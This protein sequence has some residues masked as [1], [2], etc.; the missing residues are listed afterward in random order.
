M[1]RCIYTHREQFTDDV[2]L[3]IELVVEY[4]FTPG[5]P[6]RGDGPPDRCVPA[7]DPQ[8]DIT[9]IA[10]QE[11]HLWHVQSNQHI[12]TLC[13]TESRHWCRAAFRERVKGEGDRE[14]ME[15]VCLRHARK[16][17]ALRKE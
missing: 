2:E 7:I 17:E 11:A 14:E 1:G 6:A 3:I 8:I 4:N 5:R 16:Q 13:T 9:R 10:C 12:A 15:D